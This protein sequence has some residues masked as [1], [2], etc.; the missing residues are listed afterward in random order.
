MADVHFFNV[1]IAEEYG[2]NSAI[3]LQ[4]L[5]FWISHNKAND[6]H[7]HDG[8]Y[9]TYNS[10]EAFKELFPYL[11]SKQIRTALDKLRDD[12][13]IVTGNYNQ[14]KYDRTLWYSITEKGE[15]LLK[16]KSICPTGNLHLP[17]RAN[18]FA[19]EGRPIPDINTDIKPNNKTDSFRK[20]TID[21]VREY[22]EERNNCIDAE[23][24][25]SYYESNG[26][27]VG[28]NPMKDWKAA[29][30]TWERNK[31]NEYDYKQ[32]QGRTKSARTPEEEEA[33]AFIEREFG[34][35]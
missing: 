18:A 2:I 4:N 14:A 21:E 31:S 25:F 35:N 19:P 6:K 23:K 17:Y 1:S 9:W 24:F 33:L 32:K 16:G 28:K 10:T 30:R 15:S 29:I 13:I 7:F 20:P 3:I 12:G 34:S 11:T 8:C 22:C 26:W 27:K 5:Y